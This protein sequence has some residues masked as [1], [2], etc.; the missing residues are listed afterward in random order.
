M[1]THAVVIDCRQ[2]RLRVRGWPNRLRLPPGFQPDGADGEWVGSCSFRR[3]VRERMQQADVAFA[4]RCELPAVAVPAPPCAPSTVATRTAWLAARQ[5]GV[6][7]GVPAKQGHELAAAAV[8][9]VARPALIVVPDSAA[10][11]CWVTALAGFGLLAPVVR[12]LPAAVAAGQMHW[13]CDQHELLIVDALDVVP[14]PRLSALCR[15]SAAIARLGL[16]GFVDPRRMLDWSAAL[17]PVLAITRSEG[18]QTIELRVPLPPAEREPYDA[19]WHEFLCAYDAWAVGNPAAGFGAFV[20]TARSD[21]AMRPGLLA[22][23]RALRLAAWNP[24]KAAVVDE[25]LARHRGQR[26]VVFTPDRASAYAL[27]RAHLVPAI[28]AELPRREREA[29]VGAFVVGDLRV[30]VGPRLLDHGLPE[31]IADV[32]ILVGGGLGPAQR[33]ARLRRVAAT[34]V[35][36][37]LVGLGTIEVGRARRWGDRRGEWSRIATAGPGASLGVLE[38]QPDGTGRGT[39]R[40]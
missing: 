4:D 36:Y 13:L 12:V 40:T 35:V 21:V 7:C 3:V 31:A 17:G 6:V 14:L 23:H 2:G 9:A 10:A 37:E 18:R 8:H 27:A 19:A 15:D 16:A 33:Q 38:R 32:G 20:A 11:S 29:M 39:D 34:G 24:G 5:A 30:V 28:T 22:W 25:L 1:Q 26:I